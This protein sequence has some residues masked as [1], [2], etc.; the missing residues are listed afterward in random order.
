MEELAYYCDRHGPSISHIVVFAWDQISVFVWK[1]SESNDDSAA[2][3]SDMIKELT[4]KKY[5]IRLQ[6]Y[7]FT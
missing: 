5:D 4:K 3:L 7:K 1:W 6:R 2:V